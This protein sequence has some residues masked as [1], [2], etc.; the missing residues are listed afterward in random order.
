MQAVR[1]YTQATQRH[2]IGA[3]IVLSGLALAGCGDESATPATADTPVIATANAAENDTAAPSSAETRTTDWALVPLTQGD[4]QLYLSVM[5]AAAD[6]V[7]HPPASDLAALAL[8]QSAMKKMQDGHPEQITQ[9]EVDVEDLTT[10]LDGHVDDLIVADRHLD[11]DRYA[12]IVDRVEDAVVP[13]QEDFVGDGD[14]ST[15]PYIPTAHERAIE[16]AHAANVKTLAPFRKEIRALEAVVR[17]ASR[18][19]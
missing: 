6:R 10:E 19:P 2:A 17:D 5:R 8:E 14:P 9:A 16:A 3:L 1:R 11:A 18:E 4:I 7:R 13:P 12:R 15:T